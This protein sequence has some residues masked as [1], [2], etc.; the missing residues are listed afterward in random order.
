MKKPP[1]RAFEPCSCG[2]RMLKGRDMCRTCRFRSK[3]PADNRIRGIC[4]GCGWSLRGSTCVR[5]HLGAA[6]DWEQVAAIYNHRNPED[7]ITPQQAKA[8]HQVA[9]DKLKR[10]SRRAKEGDEDQL[11]G[12]ILLGC[13]Y[14]AA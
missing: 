1:Q 4:K 14:D 3:R 10:W 2:R 5:C 12:R 8:H 11:V 13:L 7:P 9:L 6:L